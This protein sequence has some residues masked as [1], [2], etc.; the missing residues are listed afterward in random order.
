M[1]KNIF[2]VLLIF[3]LLII[4]TVVQ[5]ADIFYPGF[6]DC[7]VTKIY[8]GDS[9]TVSIPNVPLV[10]G[11]DI[12]VRVSHI[13]TPEIRGVCQ[14]EK[15]MAIKAKEAALRIAPIGS[16]VTLTNVRRDKYFRI[17]ADI[18]ANG[19]DVGTELLRLKLAVPYEGDTKSSWCQ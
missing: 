18:N 17:L 5:S 3:L 9:I 19:V 13:D 7:K 12:A 15:D 4:S 1:I 11:D 8:D 2:A 14:Y 10:L 16:Y 6:T